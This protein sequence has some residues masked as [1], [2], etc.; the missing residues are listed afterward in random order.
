MRLFFAITPAL[1]ISPL[2]LHDALPISPLSS[3]IV[4]GGGTTVLVLANTAI[5]AGSSQPVGHDDSA[6][7]NARSEEHTSELQSL[8][9]LVCSLLLEKKT[10]SIITPYT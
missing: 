5:T 1:A 3:T 4:S 8:R 10:C 2:S 9:H 7:I 6:A